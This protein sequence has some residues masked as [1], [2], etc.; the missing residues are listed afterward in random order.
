MN[1]HL[2]LLFLCVLLNAIQGFSQKPVQ[3]ITGR[4]IDASTEEGLPFSTVKLSYDNRGMVTDSLGYFLFKD[5]PVGRYSVEASYV[6]YAPVLMK[7]VIVTSSKETVVEI[8]L[9]ELA[10]ELNEV[11]VTPK[12]IKYQPLN[13]MNLSSGRMLSV[14]EAGRFAGGLDDPARLA[15]AF[16]GVATNIGDNGITVR[17]NAP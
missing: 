2:A 12:V 4:V 10:S 8:P 16:A 5:I 14:E 11:V 1:R 17:G 3:S 7:D 15:G 6:G 13:N 9:Q